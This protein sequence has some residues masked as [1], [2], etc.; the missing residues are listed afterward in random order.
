MSEPTPSIGRIVHYTSFGTP[1][2]E[3]KSECRAAIITAV[4][5]PPDA[6]PGGHWADL[7]VF[8]PDGIFLNK[9]CP[10]SEDEHLGG[11]WHWPERV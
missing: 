11:T 5:P 9:E 10:Q 3:Y 4:S 2:G 1:N 8:N 6:T 7:T